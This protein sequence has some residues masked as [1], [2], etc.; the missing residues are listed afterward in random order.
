MLKWIVVAIL[1]LSPRL[2]LVAQENAK[3]QEPEYIKVVLY[4]NP[5]TGG[6][7]PILFT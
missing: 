1:M 4:L 2:V 7:E 5:T 3:V 6:L